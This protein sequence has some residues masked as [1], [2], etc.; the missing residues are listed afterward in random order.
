MDFHFD[1]TASKHTSLVVSAYEV[2]GTLLMALL[3]RL[4]ARG[5]PGRFLRYWSVGW[6]ALAASAVCLALSFLVA[7]L[8][9][10]ESAPWLRRPAIA[11]YAA[12][13][14]GFGFF[15]WAGCREYAH[16]TTR[17]SSGG[18][19]T[20]SRGR[21][22]STS[23]TRPSTTDSSRSCSGSG[24]WCWRPTPCGGR[25]RRRTASWRRRTGCWPRR[26][27]SSGWPPEPTR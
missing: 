10:E 6:V 27:N 17:W 8:L 4:L 16:G 7:P 11:A 21:T 26:P 1:P 20:R 18:C 15:L 12:F 2:A 19:S 14:C 13:Q 9:P 22:S 5:I 3:L 25:W 24:W 23:T